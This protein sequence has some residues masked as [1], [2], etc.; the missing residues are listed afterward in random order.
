M[1]EF[2]R[3]IN[4]LLSYIIIMKRIF[5]ILISVISL[6]FFSTD[7]I[8]AQHYDNKTVEISKE[9]VKVNNKLF[10]SHIVLEKQT[11]YSI[12]KGYNVSL[13]EIYAA[14]PIIK[15]EGL[16]KNTIILIPVK[17]A[18]EEV[19]ARGNDNIAEGNERNEDA[20]EVMEEV[21]TEEENSLNDEITER[22]EKSEFKPKKVIFRKINVKYITHTVKWFENIGRI[23][24]KYG[25]SVDIIMEI[26]NLKSTQL[27]KKQKLQI[28]EDTNLYLIHR[29]RIEKANKGYKVVFS[30]PS[31]SE[32]PRIEDGK[33]TIEEGVPNDRGETSIET[34]DSLIQANDTLGMQ[35]EG[36]EEGYKEMIIEYVGKDKVCAALIMPFKVNTIEGGNPMIMDFYSGVLLAA[37]E[38][39]EAG[40]NLNL[41]VFDLSK[42]SLIIDNINY[43]DYDFIIG[44]ISPNEIKSVLERAPEHCKIISPLDHRISEFV[45]QSPQL[46]QIPTKN[47]YQFVELT[48]WLTELSSPNDTIIILSEKTNL[49]NPLA[50][51]IKE[52]LDSSKI[53]H[54]EL[55][56]N[57]LEGINIVNKLTQLLNKEGHNNIIIASENEAF[58]NDVI[59]NMNLLVH[60]KYSLSIFATAKTK[61]FKAM[62]VES[63][64]NTNLHLAQHYYV[65]YDDIQVQNFIAKYRSL[66]QTEPSPFAFQGYDILHYFT[67]LTNVYGNDWVNFLDKVKETHLQTTFDFEKLDTDNSGY[68]NIGTHRLEYKDNYI[69][70]EVGKDKR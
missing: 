6:T 19:E 56:Y 36:G 70:E 39:G 15:K 20:E 25:T 24:E 18:K 45:P 11:L 9:K 5:I 34:I 46:I 62:E 60:E 47:D 27:K 8:H 3:T 61:S 42:D 7:L 68:Y 31:V 55:S 59:R 33:P 64:H 16:K 22:D 37:K 29:K 1:E 13:D 35:N 2:L 66:F 67:K 58:V 32:K 12:S 44:P 48:N 40:I 14:N 69:I 43:D 4:R 54:K 28:P 30:S 21:E 57:I 51:E 38:I 50:N 41:D 10:Y 52:K 26:N 65:N 63:Y 17:E 23:A 49:I 53:G